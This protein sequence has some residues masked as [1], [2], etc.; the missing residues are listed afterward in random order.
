MTEKPKRPRL[1]VLNEPDGRRF[2]KALAMEIGRDHAEVFLQIEF[3]ISISTTPLID[4]EMWTKQSV[5]NL[6]EEHFPYWGKTFISKILNDLTTG[7]QHTRYTF[8]GRG[9]TRKRTAE[10]VEIQPLLK[11]GVFNTWGTD[12]TNW[13]ALDIAGINTLKSAMLDEQAVAVTVERKRK[14]RNAETRLQENDNA[15]PENDTSVATSSATFITEIPT[16]TPTEGGAPAQ[17]DVMPEP[18]PNFPPGLALQPLEK[19]QDFQN[20]NPKVAIRSVSQKTGF[21]LFLE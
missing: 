20:H 9:R 1:M 5:A 12:V 7:Y 17:T 2:S 8:S 16:E 4:G 11:K 18:P 19:S 10:K 3:L 15:S 21:D 6:Q 14:Q 13:Y